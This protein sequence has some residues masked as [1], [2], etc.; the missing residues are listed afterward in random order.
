MHR[1]LVPE[2]LIARET[3]TPPPDAARHLKVVRPKAGEEIELF[4][5]H[6]RTRRYRWECGSLRA[7]GEL[8]TLQPPPVRLT[9]FACVTKGSRWDW[10]IEKAV[11]LGVA[12][13][14]PVISERCIVRLAANER[15][16]KAERWR[17]IAADAARQSD[18]VWLPEVREAVDFPEAVELVKEC[19]R[20]FA[21]ALTSPPPPPMWTAV[22]DA[23]AGGAPSDMG[24]FVGPEGDFAPAE[25]GALLEVAT[26]VSFGPTILR[27]E[28]AAI[29]G[30]SV[31]AAACQGPGCR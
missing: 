6:G 9:L 20:V 29:F 12:R 13:I 14:V 5:G 23:L 21:G 11:E 25:L 18:A 1:L 8:A 27:A 31:L 24:V 4:D 16:A 26:P 3:V 10:T 2:G 22:A 28:T 17:R 7:A 19:G 15:A 30:V